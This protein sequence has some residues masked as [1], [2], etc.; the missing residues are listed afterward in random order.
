VP[1]LPLQRLS[2]EKLTAFVVL[3][4]HKKN[5]ITK[6]G[7]PDHDPGSHRNHKG[8]QTKKGCLHRQPHG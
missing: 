8:K 5:E 4:P 1:P 2:I 6:E 7:I 3:N